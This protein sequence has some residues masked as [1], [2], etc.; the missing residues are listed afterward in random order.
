MTDEKLRTLR[1]LLRKLGCTPSTT[2]AMLADLH[3]IDTR[4]EWVAALHLLMD[5]HLDA[6]PQESLHTPECEDPE[7]FGECALPRKLSCD[8]CLPLCYGDCGDCHAP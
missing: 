7:C 1:S 4:S 5:M 8:D 2:E 3:S 6:I